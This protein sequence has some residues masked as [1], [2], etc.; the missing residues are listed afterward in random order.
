MSAP[1]GVIWPP[2]AI[3]LMTS[4]P[5]SALASMTA[6]ISSSSAAAPPKK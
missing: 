1:P 2:L 3:T 6:R 4:A 5:A